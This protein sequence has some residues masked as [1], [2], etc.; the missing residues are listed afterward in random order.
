MAQ[1]ARIETNRQRLSDR[2]EVRLEVLDAAG[3]FDDTVLDDPKYQRLTRP[4]AGHEPPR[5]VGAQRRPC[6]GTGLDRDR[7]RCV[8]D[9]AR[10]LRDFDLTSEERKRL[11]RIESGSSDA[12]EVKGDKP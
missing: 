9:P 8:A 1:I 12:N 7:T 6:G 5:H 3:R 10:A 4:T 2:T 11:L